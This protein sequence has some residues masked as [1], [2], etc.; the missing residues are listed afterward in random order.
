MQI[1]GNRTSWSKRAGIIPK[2]PMNFGHCDC[3]SKW[4]SKF[5][6]IKL[7]LNRKC[8]EGCKWGCGRTGNC[9]FIL[10]PEE[11]ITMILIILDIL[12]VR[13]YMYICYSWL[14][15]L[16]WQDPVLLFRHGGP[17]K[18]AFVSTANAFF[19][20]VFVASFLIFPSW[21]VNHKHGHWITTRDYFGRNLLWSD[22]FGSDP[23]FVSRIISGPGFVNPVRS[24]PIRSGPI[25]VLLTPKYFTVIKGQIQQNCS[26]KFFLSGF[27]GFNM[28]LNRIFSKK[29]NFSSISFRAPFHL[30]FGGCTYG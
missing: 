12:R 27:S 25:Q 29:I 4:I 18:F 7:K 14:D 19:L 15:P 28:C 16:Q 10:E 11:I 22:F 3:S 17:C 13:R 1:Y 23:G 21:K 9:I 5:K 8:F 6:K 2:V 20:F 26:K 24:G 30:K